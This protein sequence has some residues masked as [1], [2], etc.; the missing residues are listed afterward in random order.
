VTTSCLADDAPDRA[1]V[2]NPVTEPQ[3]HHPAEYGTVSVSRAH[4]SVDHP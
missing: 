2:E 1:K 4:R 3:L